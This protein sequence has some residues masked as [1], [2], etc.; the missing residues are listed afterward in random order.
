M[1]ATEGNLSLTMA[2]AALDALTR[3]EGETFHLL[4]TI[5]D[6]LTEGVIVV[7]AERNLLVFNRRAEA[8][9]GFK[10]DE[11]LGR[12]C[13]TGIKCTRCLESCGVFERGHIAGV[14][15]ELFRADGSLA[16]ITKTATTLRDT[17]GKV[18]GAFEIL[19]EIDAD[20]APL[21]EGAGGAASNPWEGA[22]GL[23]ETLGRSLLVLDHELVIRRVSPTF[24]E[25]V[26]GSEASVVGRRAA[27]VLGEE[28]FGEG[29]AFREALLA[30]EKR[31]GW[32]AN[33]AA[34][35]GSLY[36]VS[37][38]A[39]PLQDDVSCGALPASEG[40][41]LVVLR[42]ETAGEREANA[43]RSAVTFE[44]M[45]AR[46]PAMHRVFALIDHLRDSDASVA[47]SGESGTGKELVARAIHARSLRANEPFVAV[48]CGALPHD[49][50]E[51]ELFGHAKGAFTGAVR[52]KPGRFEAAGKGTI[53]LDEI[54]D[55]P[56]PLQVK[57]LRV[58]QERTYERVGENQTRRFEGRV[59]SATHVDLAAEVAAGR[60]REDLFYRLNVVPL[61]LPPLRDRPEDV[62][63]LIGELMARIGLRRSRS[64]R[65]SPGAMR[66]LLSCSWPG[67]VR[68][69]E[70]A[71]EYAH[72]VCDGQT[73]HRED[74]P[75]EIGRESPELSGVFQVPTFAAQAP[76]PLPAAGPAVDVPPPA[77]RS[78]AP[79]VTA[80]VQPAAGGPARW[81]S[82]EA[83][84]AALEQARFRRSEAARILGVSRTTLWRRMRE[85]GLA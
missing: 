68:Q 41:V 80:P 49:L 54:G 50:L 65:L 48:N 18:V 44:G 55:L 74:L 32:R 67:N 28:L 58:L 17:T 45:V 53:F 73:I 5:A 14:P 33:I 62:E 76:V 42:P 34:A 29:A 59:V 27:E 85:Y 64:L 83:L 30:G 19:R 63:L 21:E 77:L 3:P 11:V 79:E 81:P 7:D 51:S 66:T 46:S 52:D 9:T 35:D 40:R 36:P 72:A 22:T 1:A 8:I 78:A 56:L 20:G 60:F 61:T 24:E 25:L 16:H 4:Q 38:T 57:L 37:V 47:I 69:L 43:T 82:R 15:L 39:A 2:S 31:E 12:H 6:H 75:A 10:R 23:M 71:L 70:N 13:L 84:V 26:G